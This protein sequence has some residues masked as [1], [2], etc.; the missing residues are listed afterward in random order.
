MGRLGYCG[1]IV[2]LFR[3]SSHSHRNSL[4]L[5]TWNSQAFV[6]LPYGPCFIGSGT[7]QS[8]FSVVTW[9]MNCARFAEVRIGHTILLA[10]FRP[11]CKLDSWEFSL[12]EC[13]ALFWGDWS[14]TFLRHHFLRNVG[15]HPVS[16]RHIPEDLYREHYR[17][18]NLKS[19]KLIA[20]PST[21]SLHFFHPFFFLN[22]CCYLSQLLLFPSLSTQLTLRNSVLCGKPVVIYFVRSVTIF[23][24]VQKFIIM[25][26][27][28]CQEATT[29]HT[30]T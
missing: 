24:A 29:V 28:S 21:K 20:F 1:T 3:Q 5:G 2:C 23:N 9:A 27:T 22:Y 19:R 18:E 10:L 16:Q 17:C 7:I 26:S 12:L 13:D 8:S 11:D 30:V 25:M 6:S 4:Y 15:K 14:P